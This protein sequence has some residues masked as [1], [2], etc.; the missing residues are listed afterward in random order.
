LRR[1]PQPSAGT[2]MIADQRQKPGVLP[3]KMLRAECRPDPSEKYKAPKPG[4]LPPHLAR[5]WMLLS[6]L[7]PGSRGPSLRPTSR[8]PVL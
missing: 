6:S 3:A 1:Q 5:N 8:R 2:M 7:G 4:V